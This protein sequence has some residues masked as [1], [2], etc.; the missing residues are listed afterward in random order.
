MASSPDAQES[1][2]ALFVADAA[3]ARGDGS[4]DGLPATLT[5]SSPR[6]SAILR[7]A[8]TVPSS[9]EATEVLSASNS[10]LPGLSPSPPPLPSPGPSSSARQSSIASTSASPAAPKKVVLLRRPVSPPVLPEKLAREPVAGTSRAGEVD[11]GEKLAGEARKLSLSA[12]ADD[13]EMDAGGEGLAA[14]GEEGSS[15]DP[16]LLQ[17][18]N[19]PRD[20]FLLLRAEVEMERFVA[21]PSATRLPLAPPHFQPGLNSYQRLLI[22]RL[23]DIFGITREVEAAPAPWNGGPII[24]PATGQP[25]G[26]VVL[27]KGEA[28]AMPPAKLSTYVP[29]LETASPPAP[30]PVPTIASPSPV[31]SADL[32]ATAVA[33][34]STQTPSAPSPNSVPSQPQQV[35]RILPRSAGSRAASSTSSNV[36]DDESSIGGSGSASA[37]A[38]GKGRRELTLEEREAAY[39]EARDRIFSQPEP[40]RS[41]LVPSTS[42]ATSVASE[43]GMGITRPSSAGSTFSRSSAAYSISGARPSP[44]LASESSSSMRSGYLGYY[45]QPSPAL[46]YAQGSAA[47]PHLR[48]SAPIF[49]P[50]SGG[51]MYPQQQAHE[52]GYGV[53]SGYGRPPQPPASQPYAPSYPPPQQAAYPHHHQSASSYAPPPPRPP[54]QVTAASPYPQPATYTY[55]SSPTS[56][57]ANPS[58]ALPHQPQPQQ[59]YDPSGHWQ[60]PPPPPSLP[61]PSLS[62]S[63][64]ASMHRPPP[65]PQTTSSG[66][67][68]SNYLMRFADGA[69][70]TPGG[71]VSVLAPGGSRS[72]GSLS[73]ASVA[74]IS[75]LGSV[76]QTSR[77]GGVPTGTLTGRRLSASTTHS[78]GSISG[79]SSAPDDSPGASRKSPSGASSSAAA[80]EAGSVTGGS[81]EERRRDRQMTI[82]GG[83]A[84]IGVRGDALKEKGRSSSRRSEPEPATEEDPKLHPSLPSKPAWV[85]SQ[86][87]TERTPPPTAAS[88]APQSFET[89]LAPVQQPPHPQPHSHPAY[90]AYPAPSSSA[91]APPPDFYHTHPSLPPSQPSSAP[92]WARPA[93][94]APYAPPPVDFPSLSGAPP[95]AHAAPYYPLQPAP[96]PAPPAVW[97]GSHAASGP[98]PV[99]YLP[100]VPLQQQQQQ[101]FGQPPS[102]QDDLMVIPDMRRPP[103]RSTQLFDPSKPLAGG[104]RSVSGGRGKK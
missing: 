85:A 24:N 78:I 101:A 62:A 37:S 17:A 44:S 96:P 52:Y 38:K 99:Q 93:A 89:P 86:P 82:V 13:G 77:T 50:T 6:P 84:A 5:P 20:R 4:V 69:V 48:P 91:I 87:P 43:A 58:F 10:S 97:L 55:E 53:D 31:A 36:G 3:A 34:R 14:E 71:S 47:Y 94:P 27:V 45:A 59:S 28:T 104:A 57:F 81:S 12:E 30:P 33:V 83:Q 54:I 88:L 25:Q 15:L 41:Q 100:A 92:A 26:V 80:S 7:R 22:H 2:A 29:T 56:T 60:H 79:I 75:S 76:K 16:V 90:P 49:D 65:P 66:S 46:Q 9:P 23:A 64:G 103:P 73:S 35:F 102:Q 8:S 68:G 98:Q 74:S 18:L 42:A 32:S 40:E 63:S 72:V 95:P 11:E 1:T 21:T 67:S 61:S 51:W 70:V 19:H 39:K